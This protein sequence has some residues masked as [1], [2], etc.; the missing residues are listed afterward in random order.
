MSSRRGNVTRH[1]AKRKE[2]SRRLQRCR[3]LLARDLHAGDTWH[4]G[5]HFPARCGLPVRL[6]NVLWDVDVAAYIQIV[7]VF[8]VYVFPSS[9]QKPTVSTASPVLAVWK[10]ASS[11][12]R[13]G[14]ETLR[15]RIWNVASS[16]LKRCVVGF[17]LCRYHEIHDKS[18][19]QWKRSVV[20]FRC[21]KQAHELL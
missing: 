7:V 8:F 20:L 18:V 10:V 17:H 19:W 9:V 3:L 2:K 15:R 14:S 6:V 21:S 5:R 11:D 16:D 4:H 13:F 12:Y 1:S